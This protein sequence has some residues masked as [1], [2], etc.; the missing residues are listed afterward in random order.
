MHPRAQEMAEAL[1]AGHHKKCR[2]LAGALVDAADP[3]LRA[4]AIAYL[5]ESHLAEG[6]FDGARAAARALADQGLLRRIET[7]ESDYRMAINRLQR[8]VATTRSQADAARA[9]LLSARVHQQN[10]RLDRAVESYWKVVNRFPTTRQ[11]RQAMGAIIRIKWDSADH[12]GAVRAAERG[13]RPAPNGAL[14]VA[15]CHALFQG[16][17]PTVGFEH[18]DLIRHLRA[19][20]EGYSGTAASRAAALGIGHLWLAQGYADLAEAKWLSAL[21]SELGAAHQL[22]QQTRRALARIRYERA[23]S[24]NAAGDGIAS[25]RDMALVLKEPGWDLSP[26]GPLA[27]YSLWCMDLGRH[28]SADWYE[29]ALWALERLSALRSD[30]EAALADRVDLGVCLQALGRHTEA[31]AELRDVLSVRPRSQQL[32]DRALRALKQSE[33]AL[34]KESVRAAD[35]TAT[36]PT[37]SGP[38]SAEYPEGGGT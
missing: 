4:Q 2:E 21:A 8:I 35:V 32:A 6:D 33:D 10:H 20:A 26:E 30:P 18:D 16:F 9:Q 11:A 23:L 13:I 34:A 28:V 37:G 19:V 1:G 36:D 5:I 17:I 3:V 22:G 15:A 29:E 12:E 7:A 24:A 31:V 14:A 25:V 38:G 27:L